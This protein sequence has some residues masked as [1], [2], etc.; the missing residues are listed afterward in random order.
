MRIIEPASLVMAAAFSLLGAQKGFWD[1]FDT[2]LLVA[3]GMLS[4]SLFLFAII[5]VLVKRWRKK[6]EIIMPSTHEQLNSYRELFEDGNLT[7][8]EFDR[9][10]M[11]LL[12]RMRK[13][14]G[15]G[16]KPAAPAEAATETNSVAAKPAAPSDSP[17]NPNR[18][19]TEDLKS[20]DR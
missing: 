10:R 7:K 1:I 11:R 6:Q 14:T 3:G 18:K 4:G 13:E 5:L 2:R 15:L 17:P 9:I 19:P 16:E 8:E 12:E 20:E